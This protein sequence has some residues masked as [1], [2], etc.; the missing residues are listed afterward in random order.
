MIVISGIYKCLSSFETPLLS[1]WVRV[2]GKHRVSSLAGVLCIRGS[3]EQKGT[4][5]SG[6]PDA[7][8]CWMSGHREGG[9]FLPW[10]ACRKI[11]LKEKDER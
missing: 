11:S 2:P 6:C 9:Q 5:Q 10:T 1:V 3:R 4:P 8:L 7:S